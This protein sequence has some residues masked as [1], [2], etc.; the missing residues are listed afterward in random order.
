MLIVEV[1]Q[2]VGLGLCAV[3]RG[4]KSPPYA[5][6][7]DPALQSAM[8]SVQSAKM[9]GHDPYAYL[10]D[11]LARLPTQPAARLDELLPHNW[12]PVSI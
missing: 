11:I 8:S 9:N 5:L 4:G 10:K 7:P 2:F 6:A 3:Y 12:K 1:T